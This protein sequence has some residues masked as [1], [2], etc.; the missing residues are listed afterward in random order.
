MSIFRHPVTVP[1]T[2]SASSFWSPPIW[3]AFRLSSRLS[4]A[5]SRR[6]FRSGGDPPGRGGTAARPR[7]RPALV[8]E[9]PR[10]FNTIDGLCLTHGIQRPEVYV[11]DTRAG[12]ALAMAGRNSASIVL[13]T[14]AA[15][16]LTWWNSKPWWRTCWCGVPMRASVGRRRWGPW[17]VPP[18]WA[19]GLGRWAPGVG[20]DRMVRADFD[21][22][23][24]TR[25]PPGMQEAL[26]ALADLGARWS[27]GAHG[28]IVAA[29]A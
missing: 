8:G 2:A 18:L 20:R 9:F 12:N 27:P 16:R 7:V 23:E 15:D 1:S 21:G 24:L 17:T 13:T 14:G 29:P 10:L 11:L 6:L 3:S 19:A 28:P 22:A 5:C 4:S 25:F 26:R